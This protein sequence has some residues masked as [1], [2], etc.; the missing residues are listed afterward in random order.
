MKKILHISTYY[1]PN[2][3]GVEQVAYDIV[4][5]LKDEY[6]QK[7]I[8]F[9]HEK[10]NKIDI[11]DGVEINRIG[12]IKKIASQAISFNYFFI[13]KKIIKEFN[14]DII[15]IH[16]PNPLI[17]LY[18]LGCNLKNKK[19]I[20]HWHSDI[21]DQKF[22]KKLYI[23]IQNMIIKRADLIFVTSPDYK[24]ES[25]DLKKYLN[26]IRVIPNIVN[27]E[28]LKLNSEN[29]KNIKIIKEKYKNKKI[30][31][32]LG[33]HVPYKGLEYLIEA[34]DFISD[35]AI[36]LI[37]GQGPLTEKLK[38]RSKDKKNIDFLGRLSNEEVKEYLYSAY[39]FLFPSITKNEAFGVAL[40]EALYCGVPAVGFEI[41]GSGVNWVNKDGYTGYMVENRNIKEY[42]NKINNLI[43]NEELR[44]E[45][46]Q[47]AKQ[48]VREN[49]LKENMLKDLKI[50]LENFFNIDK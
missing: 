46:A 36:I 5:G 49:F 25:E 27:E 35:K 1:L 33:R 32:F 16:L 6:E 39:L 45:M 4:S 42:A 26:K 19:L 20:L 22:L 9:N 14:P 12:Y 13:L 8:C 47:N 30:L 17:T 38:E 41:K 48:W 29:L 10:I 44:E 31:F 24:K 40:A 3:G 23:P 43:E 15:Y 18:L 28:K 50:E 2:Y 21:I 11:Y 37:G 7:V 34:A